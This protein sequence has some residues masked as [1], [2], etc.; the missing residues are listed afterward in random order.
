MIS[1]AV[2]VEGISVHLFY[3]FLVPGTRQESRAHSS[4]PDRGYSSM[5]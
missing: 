1:V 3:C 5:E 4:F 2:E